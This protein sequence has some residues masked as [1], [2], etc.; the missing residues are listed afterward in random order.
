MDKQKT[1]GHQ[2][3]GF[4]RAPYVGARLKEKK[5]SVGERHCPKGCQTNQH[6]STT[7]G[8][9][10][11]ANHEG[12]PPTSPRLTEQGACANHRCVGA[13]LLLPEKVAVLIQEPCRQFGAALRS[14]DRRLQTTKYA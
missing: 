12:Q 5:K 6:P 7:D 2:A 1:P 4:G 9:P 3:Q 14:D 10:P 11:T 8:Q 13:D